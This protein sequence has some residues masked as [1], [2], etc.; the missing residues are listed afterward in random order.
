MAGSLF[1]RWCYPV[2]VLE[3]EASFDLPLSLA[4]P[5]AN[6]PMVITIFQKKTGKDLLNAQTACN[7]TLR[8]KPNGM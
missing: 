3:L 4:A 8:L 2:Q 5:L 6:P 1:L 7:M